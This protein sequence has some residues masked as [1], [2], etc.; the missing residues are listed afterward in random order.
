MTEL[1]RLPNPFHRVEPHRSLPLPVRRALWSACELVLGNP[2]A[3]GAA[4]AW[5]EG[6][7]C[8]RAVRERELAKL[9]LGSDDREARERASDAAERA[10]DR[11]L[12]L[13]QAVRAVIAE[14]WHTGTESDEAAGRI[15]LLACLVCYHRELPLAG[16]FACWTWESAGTSFAAWLDRERGETHVAGR[17]SVLFGPALD[18]PPP[19]W[20]DAFV[21]LVKRAVLAVEKSFTTEYTE[22]T[23]ER[24]F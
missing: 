12:R 4:V 10:K 19:D 22:Y 23:E 7:F 24:V 1:N 11:G 13:E 9:P 14:G 20:L 8:E 21:P 5:L 15:V 3:F 6:N 2:R 17:C 18:A 16:E